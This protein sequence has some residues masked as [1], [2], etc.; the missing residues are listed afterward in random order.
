MHGRVPNGHGAVHCPWKQMSPGGQQTCC[1]IVPQH[2]ALQQI[3]PVAVA[4][5]FVPGGHARTHSPPMHASPGPQQRVP[6]QNVPGSQ[7][8]FSPFGF[9]HGA[10]SVGQQNSHR[11]FTHAWPSGQQRPLQQIDPSLQQPAAPVS[12]SAQNVCP[13]AQ[14]GMHWPPTHVE[15]GGQM[16]P[17]SPQLSGSVRVSVHVVP[18]PPAQHVSPDGQ[19]KNA[20]GDPQ[21]SAGQ[22]LHAS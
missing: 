17:Q 10:W 12:G 20:P 6:Q 5:T 8:N 13:G 11:P 21:R 1:P 3:G 9:V 14:T 15:S 16:R 18:H 2:G 19:Q 22:A 7:Q 4:Q